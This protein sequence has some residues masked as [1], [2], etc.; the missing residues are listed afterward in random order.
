[1]FYPL[2]ALLWSVLPLVLALVV[3]LLQ[4]VVEWL[5]ISSQGSLVLVL[6]ALLGVD[7][8]DA[9]GLSVYLH[10]G[11][12]LAALTYFRGDVTRLLRM[13]SEPD[14][15]LLRFLAV[16]TVVTGA[17]GLPFFLMARVASVYGEALL[18]LTGV[19]LILMGLV[20]RSARRRG[21]RDAGTLSRGESVLLGVVQ[22]LSAVPG[23]SRSGVTVSALLLRGFSGEEALR[24][25]FLMSIP[26]VFAAAAGLTVVG[27][28][29][30]PGAELLV[31]VAASFLS[32]LLS[33]DLLL[34]VAR[35]VRF[36]GL[37]IALGALA[38]LPL[39]LY[40]L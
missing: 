11:T 20:E 21:G 10:I 14:R 36:W 22:G 25:S 13:A 29:P 18:G 19:A 34:R 1:V 39:A 40:L 28:A 38:L 4:G 15:R 12:G 31:A 33:I 35:R 26:A 24:I 27:G 32:A 5:P 23:I 2:S 37:C 8:A 30:P 16:A 7:P 17:V 3:G 9:L 6:V